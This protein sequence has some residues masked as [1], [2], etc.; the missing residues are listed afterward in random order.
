MRI[1]VPIVLTLSLS[2]STVLPGLAEKKTNQDPPSATQV[3][4]SKPLTLDEAIRIG[5]Q[6][7]NTLGIA[8]SQLEAAKARVTQARAQY[9]PTVAPLFEYQNAL[10][11]IGGRATRIDQGVT[12]IGLRQ[13]VF[14]MGKREENLASSRS[15]EKATLYNVYD[16]RQAVIVNVTTTYYE[17][18][19]RRELVR[20]AQSS[21]DRA[22][23]TLDATTAFA[24]A[25]TA[26]K[27]DILQAQA[28]Y[29]NA[30]V[31]LSVARNDV[32][33]ANTSLKSAIGLLTPL[34]I[35]TQDLALA[36]P[37]PEPDT[38]G[39]Q[40]YLTR[41]FMARPDLRREAEFINSDRHQVKIAQINAGFQVQ[42]DV[43]EGYRIDPNPGE[44]R[45]FGTTFSYPLFDAGA[46]RAAVRQARANLEQSRR[47]LDLTKQN[48][49]LEV[50]QNFLTREESR[51]RYQATQ[52]ALKA[53]QENY[54]AAREAQKEGAG[55]I[56]D[57][58]T[59][60]TALVTAETNAVQSIYDFYTSDA[61]LRRATGEN[62]P[63]LPKGK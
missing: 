48:V 62:D 35:I 24:E 14:D 28:D 5:L 16:A 20:V 63:Y 1:L 31:Q 12:S 3:D 29:D 9:Y 50:E 59:A 25:G 55:T 30:L 37:S 53:A 51:L 45:T 52:S 4:L 44:N 18:Q 8:Q 32:R 47:Q 61:R 23:T 41:A 58:I 43:T 7:Q 38:L 57:V 13:L 34:P 11:S 27:K 33:L 46:S 36:A 56:I 54:N 39:P 17:L 15:S 22:K 26:P 19:R 2:V 10:T 49:Q 42:A 60:Q 40:D 6:N 21:V